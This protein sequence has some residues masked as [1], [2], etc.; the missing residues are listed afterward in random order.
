MVRI[1]EFFMRDLL[2]MKNSLD[3]LDSIQ[4]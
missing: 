4:N 1:Q 2:K 3:S